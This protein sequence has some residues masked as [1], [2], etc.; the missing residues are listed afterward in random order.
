MFEETVLGDTVDTAPLGFFFN[1][2][3]FCIKFKNENSRDFIYETY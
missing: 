2:W 3:R 1:Y